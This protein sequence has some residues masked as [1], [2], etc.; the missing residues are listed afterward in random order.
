MY[1]CLK[2]YLQRLE[3]EF[4]F[5]LNKFI[6]RFVRYQIIIFFINI[7]NNPFVIKILRFVKG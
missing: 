2:T 4:E 6:N 7:K 3:I 5:R 1:T